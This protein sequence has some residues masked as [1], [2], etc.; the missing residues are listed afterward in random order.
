VTAETALRRSSLERLRGAGALGELIAHQA[1]VFAADEKMDA[2]YG[3]TCANVPDDIVN[4][5]HDPLACA[6]ALG[7]DRGV[8]IEE[9]PI[10]VEERDGWLWERIDEAGRKTR[11]VRKIDGPRFGEF[12]VERITAKP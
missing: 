7:W 4:F 2:K 11:V 5:Q 8:E 3:A 10:A 6:I 1:E 12:W 9:V